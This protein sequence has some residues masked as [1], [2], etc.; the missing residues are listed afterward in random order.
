M[1]IKIDRKVY[2]DA[3]ISKA[4]YSLSKDYAISRNLEG[5]IRKAPHNTSWRDAGTVQN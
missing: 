2:S 4:I 1:E 3:C 5:N